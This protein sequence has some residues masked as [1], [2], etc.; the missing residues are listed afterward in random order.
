MHNLVILLVSLVLLGAPLAAR[1]YEPTPENLAAREWFQDAKFGVFLHWGVYSVLERGEWVMNIE[2]ITVADYEPIAER[3]NPTEFDADAWCRLF[4]AAGAKYVTI[5]SKHHDGF[6]MWD[7]K[8]TD[9]DIVDRTPYGK[10]VLKQLAEACKRHDLKLFFYHS[11]LDWRHP[12]YFPRGRTGQTA[13][14]P[15]EGDFD[16]YVDF[17]NAQLSEL[18]GGEY[19]EVAGIW[20]DGW[21][22]QQSKNFKE[23]KDAPVKQTRID[24]RLDETYALIHRLQPAALIG[25]NHHVEPFAGEDFQMFERDLP[26]QNK[27]GFSPDAVIGQLPLETCDTINGA[28]GYNAGDHRHKSVSQLVGY[29]VRAAGL[30]ANLLLNVGPKPDGTIDDVSAERLR[31]VGEW[32][33]QYGET[34]YGTRGGPI[35]PQAW[36]VT[37]AKP[38]TIYVHLL[39]RPDADGEGW[40][41]L[42]GAGELSGRALKVFEGGEA[43]ESRAGDDGSLAVRLPQADSEAIDM[44]LVATGD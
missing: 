14:R 41:T 6:A 38:G 39:K 27:G 18:L 9:W 2:K 7:S 21:W 4:K 36:G 30:N 44:V 17:M 5:T 11:Q 3:F 16:K 28:W 32:L 22:D 20:F 24:W 1:A 33:D 42:A 10:D 40:T 34:I 26:G 43:V 13:G 12:D 8:V 35:S 25:S 23:T 37:T 29:L 31:G 15:D 19:G